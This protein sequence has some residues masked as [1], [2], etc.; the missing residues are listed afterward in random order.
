MQSSFCFI[1]VFYPASFNFKSHFPTEAAVPRSRRGP[2]L[3]RAP[4]RRGPACAGIRAGRLAASQATE[5]DSPSRRRR[6]RRR[7]W[8]CCCSG[9]ARPGSGSLPPSPCRR[10]LPVPGA[11]AA[12]SASSAP[13]PP[14]S[15]GRTG[16]ASPRWP[17]PAAGRVQ[18]G[19]GGGGARAAR[20]SP[21]ESCL[22]L[23]ACPCRGGRAPSS[24]PFPSLRS[25]PRPWAPPLRAAGLGQAA[26][27]LRGAAGA[28][29][30]P[31]LA[32]GPFSPPAAEGS[33][34]LWNLINKVHSELL[35]LFPLC[36]SLSFPSFWATPLVLNPLRSSPH[37]PPQA[38]PS[39]VS[40][41]SSP[42]SA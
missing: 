27:S 22:R 37:T 33:P 3:S 25:F 5:R 2:L 41:P 38:D 18:P 20:P 39:D 32:P 26:E 30:G 28:C 16:A 23:P 17:Q 12:S 34:C 40:V 7:S 31:S 36:V 35:H 14:S 21:A 1:Y 4:R 29:S 6:R 9:G 15:E 13:T 24:L 19:G 10:R 42:P 11:A 8:R